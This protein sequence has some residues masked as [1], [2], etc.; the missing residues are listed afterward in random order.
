MRSQYKS[1]E[2]AR[3]S[4]PKGQRQ[5]R[6][7]KEL[8]EFFPVWQKWMAPSSPKERPELELAAAKQQSLGPKF[9]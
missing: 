6:L 9:D 3:K 2:K 5:K 1:V 4:A 7:E 8:S